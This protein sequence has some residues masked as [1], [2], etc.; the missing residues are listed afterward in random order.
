[1]KN[2]LTEVII[3]HDNN[4]PTPDFDAQLNKS[5][6]FFTTLK[7][8]EARLPDGEIRVT[9]GSFGEGR[10][11]LADD[12]PVAAVRPIVKYLTQGV[13][14]RDIFDSVAATMIKKGDAYR[15]TDEA[16]HPENVIFVLTAFG[17]DNASKSYTF[18]QIADMIAHQS[19][20]YRWKFFC[21]TDEPLVPEQLGIP[22]E[23]V[24]F[25]DKDVDGF[26]VEALGELAE[27]IIKVVE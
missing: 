4:A 3:L 10:K 20:V 22:D 14:R 23:D 24:I 21:L 26:F 17:R 6:S 19:Y 27:K 15:D 11:I 5:K 18:S 12:I 8:A 2:G 7:K 9:L 13:G 16:E 25:L 1:M